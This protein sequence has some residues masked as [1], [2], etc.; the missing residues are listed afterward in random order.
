[1]HEAILSRSKDQNRAR[2]LL[3]IIIA[4][5]RPLT[6]KEMSIALAIEDHHRS[7]EDL[8][9]GNDARFETMVKRICGLF[10]SVIDQRIYLLHQT[11]KEFLVAKSQALVGRWKHSFNPVE[12]ELIIT[13]TC[14]AYLLFTVVED[15]TFDFNDDEDGYLDYASR[16]WIT[17][18]RR[19]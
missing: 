19:V 10:V 16:F 1:M 15:S 3:H 18:Y 7:Y 5:A 2:K 6:L 13:R 4:A 14:L 9:I 8:D 11:A 17:H 12:S